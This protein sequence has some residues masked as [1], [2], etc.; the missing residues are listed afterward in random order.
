MKIFL[1]IK[2]ESKIEIHQR[3][4][5]ANGLDKASGNDLI[6]LSDSDEIPDMERLLKKKNLKKFTAFLKVCLCTN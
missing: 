6:I 4:N 3:N 1:I 5:L 2:I